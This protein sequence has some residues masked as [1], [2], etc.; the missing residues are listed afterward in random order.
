M[1][2]LKVAIL[3]CAVD[4]WYPKG[5]DRLMDSLSKLNTFGWQQASEPRYTVN[6]KRWCGTYPPNC[7]RHEMTPYAFK[8]YAYRAAIAD[9]YDIALWFDASMWAVSDITPII[10]HVEQHGAATWYAGWSAGE[11]STDRA[12]ERMGI[13]RDEG[14]NIPLVCGGITGFDLRNPRMVELLNQ[15]LAYANDGASFPGDWDNTRRTCSQDTR[16]LGHRHD[17]PTLSFLVKRFGVEPISCPKWFAYSTDRE[18]ANPNAIIL[19]RGM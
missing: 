19:A 15:W 7:P 16:C 17:M 4:K 13:T 11:W 5:Q 10:E 18:P 8:P 14:M 3:N 2:T 9:G 1:S 6:A 12:L